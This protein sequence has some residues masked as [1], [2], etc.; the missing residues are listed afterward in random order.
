MLFEY[1][2]TL[3][4]SRSESTRAFAWL[5]RDETLAAQVEVAREAG[6]AVC[7]HGAARNVGVSLRP[8]PGQHAM[9]AIVTHAR[10]LLSGFENTSESWRKHAAVLSTSMVVTRTWWSSMKR[11]PP[12]RVKRSL[13][14][15]PLHLTTTSLNNCH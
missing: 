9:P 14:P 6:L 13:P 1:G 3:C 10:S 4:T 5:E 15:L 2:C 12:P 8:R 7:A 11:S